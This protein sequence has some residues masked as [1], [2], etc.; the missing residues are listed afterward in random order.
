MTSP[1][2][3][4]WTSV[5]DRI[6]VDTMLGEQANGRQAESGW[7]KQTWERVAVVFKSYGMGH[8]AT[9]VR[10][11]FTKVCSA[12]STVSIALTLS[13]MKAMF[14]TVHALRN[15]SGFGWD[16]EL[17]RVTATESVWDEYLKVR[18]YGQRVVRG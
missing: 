1:S 17:M 2:R 10:D 18:V 4:V 14:K 3:I 5:A 12:V 7:K 11:R 13:Q 9:Q 15:L 16:S 8:T 6:L